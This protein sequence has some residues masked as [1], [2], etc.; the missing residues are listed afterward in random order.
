MCVDTFFLRRHFLC[1][2]VCFF[3]MVMYFLGVLG[4]I[5]VV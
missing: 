5:G 4:E 3:Q 1:D 2:F